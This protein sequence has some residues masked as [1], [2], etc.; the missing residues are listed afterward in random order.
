MH[1]E[2]FI[3]CW[4]GDE[5]T[6]SFDHRLDTETCLAPPSPMRSR[7]EI[8]YCFAATTR[9]SF[10]FCPSTPTTMSTF[11]HG[12]LTQSTSLT[13]TPTSALGMSTEVRAD[14]ELGETSKSWRSL[15]EVSIA[16]SRRTR[17][18]NYV[19]IATVDPGSGEPRVRTV[20]FR[21]FINNLP[22]DH[23]LNN[24]CDVDRKPCLM[25]MCTDLRSKKVEQTTQQP[26]A[27]LVWWFP[28]SS[29]QYRIRGT[30]L[31][32]GDD[33]VQDRR[34]TIARKELWGAISDSARESFFESTIP[35]MPYCEKSTHDDNSKVLPPGGRDEEGKLLHPPRNFLLMVLDPHEVDYLRLT[36]AQYRQID[37]RA[38]GTDDV[39]KS[40]SWE[41]VN[42]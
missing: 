40:W 23:S 6:Q 20:V 13:T 27:E 21:G 36:G 1:H 28:K 18:S 22:P 12:K 15:L 7:L 4:T 5:W 31:L 10:G 19:Q 9:G 16:K 14:Q 41:R 30:L 32:V 39:E 24:W 17:G 33:E 26:I 2:S 29:E 42:P 38:A 35:G 34:L 25:K 8:L 11:H 37:I 3:I